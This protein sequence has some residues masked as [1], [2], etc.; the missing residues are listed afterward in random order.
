MIFNKN[1][2]DQ[3]AVHEN[4]PSRCQL[5]H[6]EF[7]RSTSQGHFVLSVPLLTIPHETM[8]DQNKIPIIGESGAGKSTLL[9]G[10][11]AM[12]RLSQ[13]EILWDIASTQIQLCPEHW[14]EQSVMTV[15]R[16]YFGF[17]FQ[18]S[19]LTRHMTVLEN[20]V[21]PQLLC[22]VSIS[23][24]REKAIFMLK[25]VLRQN[26]NFKSFM[27]KYPYLEL[28]G[29]ER[30]RV[31]L[32]QAMIND[33]LVLFADEPTGNLDKQTREIVMDAVFQ[34]VDQDKK[35]LFIWVTHH[36]DDPFLAGVTFFLRVK[37]GLCQWETV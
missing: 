14:P 37:K 35:R 34:W 12:I 4:H 25:S 6:V 24:A 1:K 23:E 33:P 36:D 2:N 10:L 29:G 31:A 26:E 3:P 5:S 15:H 21:Y 13:G 27:A 19:T 30:Q 20:L 18:D 22:G 8:M 28:S 32:A 9:N 16:K 17:A 7:R 11:A